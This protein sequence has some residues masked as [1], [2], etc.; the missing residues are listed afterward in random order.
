[1][2]YK[3]IDER[4]GIISKIKSGKYYDEIIKVVNVTFYHEKL[5]GRVYL[6]KLKRTSFRYL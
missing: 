4:Q 5:D 1:M 2:K 6:F 3:K